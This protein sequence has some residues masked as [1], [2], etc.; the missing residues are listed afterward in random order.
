[1]PN[2]L[3]FGYNASYTSNLITL[4][5]ICSFIIGPYL[6]ILSHKRVRRSDKYREG[7]K[8]ILRVIPGILF[9]LCL[10][11]FLLLILSEWC[12]YYESI[13]QADYFVLVSILL[14]LFIISSCSMWSTITVKT[15]GGYE[16][17]VKPRRRATTWLLMGTFRVSLLFLSA[18]ILTP[19]YVLCVGKGQFL[20]NPF[21][22]EGSTSPNLGSYALLSFLIFFIFCIICVFCLGKSVIAPLVP[23]MILWGACIHYY[24]GTFA[25]WYGIT[26]NGTSLLMLAGSFMNFS[27]FNRYDVFTTAKKGTTV[28][29][30]FFCVIMPIILFW[31]FLWWL[32]GYPFFGPDHVTFYPESWY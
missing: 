26:L 2:T 20:N 15:K 32:Y 5:V 16:T 21:G 19:Y 17:I 18:L 11:L 25:V 3:K 29:F 13:W 8:Q 14:V 6:L 28:F 23:C 9:M 1:M 30:H 10:T 7:K 12:T 22:S 31:F 24:D 4:F 27:F